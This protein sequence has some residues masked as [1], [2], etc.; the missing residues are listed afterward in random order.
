MSLYIQILL[1]AILLF[2]TLYIIIYVIYPGSGNDDV[3]DKLTELKEKKDIVMP[4][5]VQSKILGTNGSTVIG[6]FKLNSGDRTSKYTDSFIPLLQVENNWY[7]EVS[8]SPK[9][10]TSARLRVQTNDGG[11]IKDELIDLPQI[12]KQKWICIG[13]LREGRRFDIIY[14]NKI[15][16]SQRLENYPVIISS[17]LSVGNKGLDG[18]VIH[19]LIN[20]KRLTPNEVERERIKYVDTSNTVLEDNK[21]NVSFPNLK[22]FAQCPS[23]LPCNTITKPPSSN[24]FEWSTPYA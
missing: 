10:N 8:S 1:G 5:I 6:F 3:L 4:D 20:N 16:A 9:D 18:L 21:I 2:I 22:L 14:D 17:P 11:N 24:L 15:V 23:G 13:I 7:L 12:P 19:V